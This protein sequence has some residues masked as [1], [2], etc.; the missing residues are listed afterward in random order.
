MAKIKMRKSAP[1]IDMTPMVD[2]FFL[3]L[4]FLLLT[5]QFRKQ[6]SVTVDTPGSISET[7]APEG[8]VMTIS[9]NSEDM[10]FF[11]MDN[12][13]MD[14]SLHLRGHLLREI[15]EFYDIEFTREEIEQFEMLE[16]FSLNVQNL[17]NWINAE[18]MQERA[19]YDEGIPMDSTKSASNQLFHWIRAART[20]EPNLTVVIRGDK[21]A[22]YDRVKSVIDVMQDNNVRKFNLITNLE[23]VEV[24]L[25][26]NL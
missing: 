12:G 14:T 15:G 21:D 24:S 2:V 7:P 16:S 8:K 20:V 23:A 11:N 17:R 3:L 5:A 9:I 4:T 19:A 18:N 1:R 6:E 10:V 22:D 26:E 13:G 25:E